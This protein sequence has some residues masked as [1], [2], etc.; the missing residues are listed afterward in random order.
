[1][2]SNCAF[3]HKKKLFDL[4]LEKYQEALLPNE[5]GQ[6]STDKVINSAFSK[7]MRAKKELN[8]IYLEATSEH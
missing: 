1:M 6:R 5:Q 3:H 7:M 2:A 4:A 8:Q